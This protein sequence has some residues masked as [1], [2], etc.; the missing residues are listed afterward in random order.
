MSHSLRR[1]EVKP[2]YERFKQIV[3]DFLELRD[4]SVD[5]DEVDSQE[6]KAS[7]EYLLEIVR[8]KCLDII[9]DTSK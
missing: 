8:L 7:A 9:E 6:R 5:P 3:S 1:I 4:E 2:A